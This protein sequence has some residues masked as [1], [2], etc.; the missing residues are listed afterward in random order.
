MPGLTRLLQ[1]RGTSYKVIIAD[2]CS[3]DGD[4]IRALA[5]AMHCTYARNEKNRGKGYSVR[6]GFEQAAG[7]YFIFMDGDFPFELSVVDRLMDS[8]ESGDADMVIGDRTLAASSFPADLS[9]MRKVGSHFVSALAG[10]YMTPGY[11]DTQC[12]IKGFRME[13]AAAVL[14]Q[15]TQDRFC[16]DIELLF[17]ATRKRFRIKTIPVAVKRQRGSTVRVVRDGLDVLKAI[18]VIYFNKMTGKYTL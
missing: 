2:D 6:K 12:G 4:D 15:L 1:E 7:D 3:A 17:L 13:A 8:L 18:A 5:S 14:G 11:Y 10:R 16:F 9:L